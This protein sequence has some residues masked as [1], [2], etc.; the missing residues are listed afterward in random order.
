MSV[1][2]QGVIKKINLYVIYVYRGFALLN[3]TKRYI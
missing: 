1:Q 3:I 2:H